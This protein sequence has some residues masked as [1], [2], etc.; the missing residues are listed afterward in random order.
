M[1]VEQEGR[2]E[3]KDTIT[4]RQQ[5]KIEKTTKRERK[6]KRQRKLTPVPAKSTY[7][8]EVGAG[9]LVLSSE[10]LDAALGD[11]VLVEGLL[12]LALDLVVVSLELL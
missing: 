6:G 2:E 9:L 10:G 5:N 11:A 1:G 12:E 8:L 3:K 4:R 7:S